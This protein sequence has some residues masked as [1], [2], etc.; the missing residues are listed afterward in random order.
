VT[1]FAQC[2]LAVFLNQMCHNRSPEEM[3]FA[4]ESLP[5]LPQLFDG[6][7]FLQSARINA[8]CDKYF[9]SYIFG[10]GGSSHLQKANALYNEANSLLLDSEFALAVDKLN[11]R[12]S[13]YESILA[14]P[15]LSETYQRCAVACCRQRANVENIPQARA[16]NYLLLAQQTKALAQLFGRR[17]KYEIAERA[18]QDAIVSATT[19]ANGDY[20][21]CKP[22]YYAYITFLC[23]HRRE[24]DALP[25]IEMLQSID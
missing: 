20:T 14:L 3:A 5:D 22:Y 10:F 9:K 21:I 12:S 4:V 6:P 7:K 25:L 8:A 2:Q 19:A 11:E 1:L 15:Y 18:Y 17:R 13:F 16:R 24:D 23:E